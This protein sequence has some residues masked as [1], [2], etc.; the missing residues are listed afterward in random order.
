MRDVCNEIAA[1]RIQFCLVGDIAGNEQPMLGIGLMQLQ[2]EGA[3][4]LGA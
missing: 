3:S 1:H 4:G 2:F